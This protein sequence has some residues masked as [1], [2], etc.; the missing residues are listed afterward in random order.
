MSALQKIVIYII[1]G[2]FFLSTQDVKEGGS[3]KQQS[4]Q[5]QL[6]GG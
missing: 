3:A 6:D 2:K 4:N 1:G 5:I